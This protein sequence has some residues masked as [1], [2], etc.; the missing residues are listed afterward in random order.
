MRSDKYI[1]LNGSKAVGKSTLAAS[2]SEKGYGSVVEFY[3][4]R[5]NFQKRFLDVFDPDIDVQAWKRHT[6]LLFFSLDWHRYLKHI[7]NRLIF[8]HYYPDY[9]VQQL[10]SLKEIDALN[11]LIACYELPPLNEGFHF[12][13]D[14]DYET[15]LAR[16]EKRI[17]ANP[18]YRRD[19][20]RIK[21]ESFLKRQRRYMELVDMGYL[22]RIDANG[23]KATVLRSV[24]QII[25]GDT[26]AES[27]ADDQEI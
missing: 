25:K 3:R 4:E 24:E 13:I 21:K 1:S 15:Y 22:I 27:R 19:K 11:E 17:E 16:R 12:F 18:H 9:L 14:A 5:Y 26:D 20:T 2:L 23:D 10:G 6:A 8:D 7:N